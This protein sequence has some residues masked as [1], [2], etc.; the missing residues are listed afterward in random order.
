[1]PHVPRPQ[2]ELAA[3]R[4]RRQ[5]KS[6]DYTV[7]YGRPPKATRFKP[8]KSGNPKGRRKGSRGLGAMLQDIMRQKIL[9]TDG[10]KTKR[11]PALEVMLRRLMN[12]AMR[13]DPRAFKLVLS[14]VERYSES[15]ETKQSLE[16]MLDE[17][18]QILAE[19]LADSA[20]FTRQ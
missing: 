5:P 1:M 15:V 10:G 19:Y 16:Q 18:E 11:I 8:G 2:L 7:G 4:K 3:M 20:N 6:D 12:D 14:L 9:V 17:D 13:A